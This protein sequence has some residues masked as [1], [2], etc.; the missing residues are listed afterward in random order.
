M[1]GKQTR[2]LFLILFS[3]LA[4]TP[5][6]MAAP[7]SA[8]S[9]VVGPLPSSTNTALAKQSAAV[10]PSQGALSSPAATAGEVQQR[11]MTAAE[12]E[13]VKNALKSGLVKAGH[14]V[15]RTASALLRALDLS[16][17]VANDLISFLMVLCLGE[18]TG[19]IKRSSVPSL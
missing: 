5:C 3:G 7:G 18:N 8:M 19:L 13:R 1:V 9:G 16:A 10:A 6:H 15:K 17:H 11:P 12:K 4:Q 2:L 14:G